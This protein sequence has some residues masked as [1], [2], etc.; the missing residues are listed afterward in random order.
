M[1]RVDVIIGLVIFALD[2]GTHRYFAVIENFSG[3]FDLHEDL[4]AS[5]LC[6]QILECMLDRGRRVLGLPP[7]QAAPA[8]TARKHAEWD[9][10]SSK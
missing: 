5:R 4:L 3:F 8:T 10:R 1:I 2:F 7:G 9:L 6:P